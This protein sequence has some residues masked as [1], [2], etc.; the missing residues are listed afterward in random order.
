M[1]LRVGGYNIVGFGYKANSRLVDMCSTPQRCRSRECT[2]TVPCLVD[3][4]V[5]ALSPN[6]AEA[7]GEWKDRMSFLCRMEQE[8]AAVLPPAV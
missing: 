3:M 7:E 6:V 1:P 5:A 2:L 4:V 8:E